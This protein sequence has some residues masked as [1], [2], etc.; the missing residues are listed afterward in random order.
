MNW[1]HKERRFAKRVSERRTRRELSRVHKSLNSYNQTDRTTESRHWKHRRARMRKP[2]TKRIYAIPN[3]V[4]RLSPSKIYSFHGGALDTG[5]Q[6]SVIGLNQAKAYCAGVG[7]AFQPVYASTRFRFGAGRSQAIGK[8]PIVIPTPQT[9]FTIWVDV[10]PEDIPFLIGLNTLDRYSLQV[11]SVTNELECVKDNWKIPIKRK[12]GLLYWDLS[13]EIGVFFTKPQLER[14]HRHLLHPSTRKLYNLLRRAKPEDLTPTT[15]KTLK[16]IQKTCETCQMYAPR[17]FVFRIRDT[18]AIRFNQELLLD[19]VY[20][21]PRVTHPTR[22]RTRSVSRAANATDTSEAKSKELPVLHIVDTGT[23]FQGAEFLTALDTTTVW[24]TFVKM[25]ATTYTGFPDSML[26][27]QGSVFVSKEW[28]YNCELAEI[29]LRHTGTE[30]HNSLGAGE[31]YHALLRRVYMKTVKDHPTLSIDMC[32]AL[33]VKA[34]NSTVGPDGLCP[35]LLVF[36]VLP[37]LPK[38]CP[39]EYPS[40]KERFRALQTARAEYE[41]LV[42]RQ[43]V[44]RGMKSILPPAADHRYMPGDFLYVYREG[45]KHYTGPHLVASVEGKQVRLHVG[46]HTG[47]RSF[48][49][50]QLR[51]APL[52]RLQSM[53]EILTADN[54]GPPRIL[55]TETLP[56]NDHRAHSPEFE[57]AKRK[58]LE[59]LIERGTFRIVLE[60]ELPPNPNIIPCRF[61]LAIKHSDTGETKHKARFV[62]GGHRDKDKN[63]IVHN[64][65]NI[66]QSSIRLIM[67]LATILGFDVWSLDVRQAYIQ[68]ASQLQRD[69]YIKPKE[70]ELGPQQLLKISKLLYGLSDSGDCWC[71]TFARFHTHNLRME[72]ATGDFD[73]FFRCCSDKLV[74]LSGCYVDDV[75]QASPTALKGEIQRQIQEQFDITVEDVSKFIYTGIMC[76]TSDPELRT[77][78]QAHYIRRLKYLPAGSDFKQYR[79]LRAKIMWIVHTRPDIACAASFA[80]Q[81][82]PDTFCDE[83]VNLLNRILRYVKGTPEIM[84]IYPKMDLETL[85]LVVYADSGFANLPDGKSQLGFIICLTDDSCKCSILQFSSRKSTRVARSTMAAETLAFVDGFDNF[86]LIKHELQRLLG[87]DIPVTMLTYCQLLFD[88]LT[89]SRY[90]TERRLMVDIASAREAYSNGLIFNI[91]LILSEHNPADSL[92]KVNCNNAMYKLRCTHRL[93]HPV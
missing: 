18:E 9:F 35:Q 47:P 21:K 64:T 75:L 83:S 50:S 84:L 72:Q 49:I 23:K 82:T 92:T 19:I 60:E 8:I 25:C 65:V 45:V 37:K 13:A 93:S 88:A 44:N 51:P 29:D 20:L 61:V 58:E 80:S 66:K 34:I 32:L 85:R 3:N 59:G 71:E 16:N 76:D 6:R 48:N 79:S 87:R 90:T 36:G 77:L 39:Q 5:A 81:T 22:Y 26:T 62:L 89:R 69:V 78:S 42:S 4:N 67:A 10:I 56:F 15:M 1:T 68:S 74:A 73:L 54:I 70:L 11:L 38:I 7:I 41:K 43:L 57:E 33:T 46:E 17:Q 28:E 52:T 31:T 27:D 53:D 86:F 12:F 91:G 63:S 14:L 24:N 55:Y 40:Q 2:Q 30:S